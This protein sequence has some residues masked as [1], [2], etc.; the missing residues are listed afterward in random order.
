MSEG[1][2]CDTEENVDIQP[3][4]VDLSFRPQ[5]NENKAKKPEEVAGGC[6]KTPLCQCNNS[7]N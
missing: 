5:K 1:R 6:F 3:I 2:N 7:W 4:L